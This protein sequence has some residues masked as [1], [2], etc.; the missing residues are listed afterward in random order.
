[1]AKNYYLILGLASDASDQ[2]IKSAY[3]RLAKELHPDISGNDSVPFLELQEAYSILN[4][5]EKRQQYDDRRVK[6]QTISRVP[7]EP[8]VRKRSDVEPLIPRKRSANPGYSIRN[9]FHTFIPSFDE[10]FDYLDQNV[11]PIAHRKT[12]FVKSIAVDVPVTSMQAF[13]GGQVQ[14]RVPIHFECN[15]CQGVG[16]VGPFVCGRCSGE[17]KLAGEYPV[18]IRFPGGI[19]DGYTMD[20]S[21]TS[22]GIRNAYLSVRFCI[23]GTF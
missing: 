15:V 7:I 16:N 20:V 14:I 5:P 9:E 23:D 19:R 10:L 8:L 18:S 12:D 1:M 2:E 4:D 11:S 3:K 6:R 22:L 21:L 17:G 13:R